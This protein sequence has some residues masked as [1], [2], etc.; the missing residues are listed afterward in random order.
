MKDYQ[1]MLI[2]T[3]DNPIWEPGLTAWFPDLKK[4]VKKMYIESTGLIVFFFSAFIFLAIDIL[5]KI[6]R[7]LKA[8]EEYEKEQEIR[9]L[10]YNRYK[11]IAENAISYVKENDLLEDFIL[12]RDIEFEPFELEYYEIED[13]KRGDWDE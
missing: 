4:E 1:T 9:N 8:D 10:L 11:Y 2:T 3:S 12:D 5:L 13:Y 6:R 7:C